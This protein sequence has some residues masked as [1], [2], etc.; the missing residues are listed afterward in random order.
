MQ[1]HQRALTPGMGL[2]MPGL[3]FMSPNNGLNLG[4]PAMQGLPMLSGFPLMQGIPNFNGQP[5]AGPASLIP[6]GLLQ[7]AAALPQNLVL[8]GNG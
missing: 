6:A 8:I 7:S 4:F 2:N 3:P 1:N 5:S